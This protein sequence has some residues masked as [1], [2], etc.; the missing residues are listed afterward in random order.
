MSSVFPVK[1]LAEN[2]LNGRNDYSP[3]KTVS[4][5]LGK[6]EPQVSHIYS[7]VGCL[8]VGPIATLRD[9]G[10]LAF[11]PYGSFLNPSETIQVAEKN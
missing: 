3:R 1:F 11:N 8:P 4:G 2:T 6:Q 7:T 9:L 10:H 5:P